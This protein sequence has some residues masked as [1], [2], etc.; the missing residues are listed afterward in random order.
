MKTSRSSQLKSLQRKPKISLRRSPTQAANKIITRYI[1][2]NRA[3]KRRN[4]SFFRTMRGFGFGA[5]LTIGTV[6]SRIGVGYEGEVSEK[7]CR[8]VQDDKNAFQMFP[9]FLRVEHTLCRLHCF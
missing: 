6:T 3:S 2:S 1:P 7:H 4:S 5:P 9:A 8:V